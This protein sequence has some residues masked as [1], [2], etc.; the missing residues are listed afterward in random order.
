MGQAGLL[1]KIRAN[2][3]LI[4]NLKDI[5][6]DQKHWQQFQELFIEYLDNYHLCEYNP[7]LAL[8]PQSFQG[9]KYYFIYENNMLV[10]TRVE[11]NHRIAYNEL[12]RVKNNYLVY[13][14][15]DELFKLRLNDVD[16]D[17]NFKNLKKIVEQMIKFV[18]GT[19]KK[20]L[21]IYG[22]PGVGK[23]YLAIRLANTL[24]NNGKKIAFISVINLINKVKASFNLSVNDSSL[25]EKLL[26]SDV[27][28]LDDIG[29]ESVSAW[30]R[31]DLLFRILND[32]ISQNKPVFFTSNFN[33]TK[34]ILLY[35]NIKNDLHDSATNQIKA[36]RIV[37][38]IRGLA[39][40]IELLGNSRR[41][42]EE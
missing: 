10:L 12:H 42:M 26:S 17:L 34:L 25:V 40:E 9:Y 24:A 1:A 30:V 6:F 37:D 41:G 39:S 32:R 28:F 7:N 18:K 8:C 2:A 15:S 19:R 33:L 36:L 35:G 29:G 4:Q 27:L 21:Y 20:G 22:N 3:E 16:Q 23:T 11:C 13:D 31:D 14:F 5:N 38:R